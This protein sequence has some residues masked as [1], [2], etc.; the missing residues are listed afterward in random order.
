MDYSLASL[1]IKLIP[2]PQLLQPYMDSQES[3]NHY[4]SNGYRY[5]PVMAGDL[6]R[7]P[8]YR[9]S[10]RASH[11]HLVHEDVLRNDGFAHEP[12]RAPS[13]A[14]NNSWHASGYDA[15][16]PSIE[17]S[18]VRPN[19]VHV[20]YDSPKNKQGKL[21]NESPRLPGQG[22]QLASA[23]YRRNGYPIVHIDNNHDGHGVANKRRKTGY[24][25]SRGKL[26]EPDCTMR[27]H[28]SHNS[29]VL[30]MNPQHTRELPASL[31]SP[32][33]SGVSRIRLATPPREDRFSPGGYPAGLSYISSGPCATSQRSGVAYR[34]VSDTPET[35]FVSHKPLHQPP[36][37]DFPT[38]QSAMNVVHSSLPTSSFSK[39]LYPSRGDH[40]RLQ[41][42][43]QVRA[44]PA[45]LPWNTN[46]YERVLFPSQ[47]A[48]RDTQPVRQKALAQHVFGAPTSLQ[49]T[50]P[51]VTEN[52]FID[53][54]HQLHQHSERPRSRLEPGSL[55]G[56][57]GRGPPQ[58]PLPNTVTQNAFVSKTTPYNSRVHK[59]LPRYDNYEHV[60][61]DTKHPTQSDGD[62]AYI[63]R[64]QPEP[65]IRHEAMTGRGFHRRPLP[66]ESSQHHDDSGL[67][68]HDVIIIDE[69]K[70]VQLVD[71]SILN[72]PMCYHS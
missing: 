68:D 37:A 57:E 69:R 30:P 58:P 66:P 49:S 12:F 35:P 4:T 61:H 70:L 34:P 5:K 6:A 64:R 31:R 53:Q 60:G 7:D 45:P 36:I 46:D 67:K 8:Q 15:I 24:I 56:Y 20:E 48:S 16:L 38:S 10:P 19:P 22:S 18:T 27:T 44:Y 26:A 33:D 54:T 13:V 3:L 41:Q 43:T 32:L 17:K 65:P 71:P 1:S 14:R 39:E 51:I 72:Y 62:P 21:N 55:L 50:G 23:Q 40:Q 2:A 9:S 29:T 52:R 63:S 59:E 42:T 11:D 47:T 25:P 28:G